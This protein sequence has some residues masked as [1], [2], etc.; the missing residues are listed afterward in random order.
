[1][2]KLLLSIPFCLLLIS[3]AAQEGSSA[4]DEAQIRALINE[5]VDLV[6]G[7]S[8][9]VEAKQ[10]YAY[11]TPNYTAI[12]TDY[13]IDGTFKSSSIDEETFKM[14]VTPFSTDIDQRVEYKLDNI[15]YLKVL[16]KTAIANYTANFSTYNKSDKL[17]GGTQVITARL[18]KTDSGWKIQSTHVAEVRDDM[19]RALCNYE[20]FAKDKNNYLL[21]VYYPAGTFFQQDH[22]NIKFTETGTAAATITTDQNEFRWE[23]QKL[24]LPK[25]NGGNQIINAGNRETVMAEL[26]KYYY[27]NQC[28]TVQKASN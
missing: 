1:M 8:S 13:L 5:I 25:E 18:V 26:V 20:V 15:H 24:Y 7:L 19:Q 10:L 17:V 9:P 14:R 22:L 12:R 23:S 2:K 4:E 16:G 28:A 3:G 11:Y 6:D 21:Q 27:P